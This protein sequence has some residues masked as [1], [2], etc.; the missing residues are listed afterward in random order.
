MYGMG[1]EKISGII[2]TSRKRLLEH[3]LKERPRPN[4]DDKI[5]TSWNGLAIVGLAKATATLAEVDPAR[6]KT[7]LKNAE[8]T[9]AFIRKNLYDEKTGILKRVY[10]EGPGETPG[11]A[12]DYAFLISGLLHMYVPEHLLI[13]CMEY[14]TNAFSELGTRQPLM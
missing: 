8:E 5:I 14:F 9:V 12:D 7:C 2:S 1:P 13:F 4:L 10:R 6:A 3:R 11:F